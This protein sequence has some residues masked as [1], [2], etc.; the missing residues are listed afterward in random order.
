VANEYHEANRLGWERISEQWQKMIA[1]RGVWNKC[2][3]SPE[4][5][6]LKDE[7]EVLG[8]V[9]GKKA[10]VLGS[11]DNLVAFA[12]AGMGAQVTSVDIAQKQLEIAA[13]RAES[14]GLKMS[15]LTADVTDLSAIPD[16]SFDVVYTGGHVAVWVSDLPKYYREAGRILKTGGLFLVNEYHPFRRIW[17][18]VPDRLEIGFKY[19][20]R[21]PHK[22]DRSEEVPGAEP[23]SLPSFEFHW[24]VADYLEAFGG[25]GCELFFLR[26]VGEEKEW[27]EG[28]PLA[29]LPQCLLLAGTRKER[30]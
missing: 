13:G 5:V 14:L 1:G 20:D 7:L 29:G 15:F 24:T 27:W 8:D 6:L 11:G 10:C 2:H 9:R 17:N 26:E 23:G 3:R 16:S 22:F 28:L 12:L 25:S 30:P 4:L 19:L 21:G 18:W